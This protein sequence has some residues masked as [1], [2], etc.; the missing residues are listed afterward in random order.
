MSFVASCT[1]ISTYF[2][3][4]PWQGSYP[5]V[6]N[7]QTIILICSGV[8]VQIIHD[9]IKSTRWWYNHWVP[10][11]GIGTHTPCCKR[12]GQE[13]AKHWLGCGPEQLAQVGSQGWHFKAVVSKNCVGLPHVGRH[14]PLLGTGSVGG[15]DVHWSKEGPWQLSQSGWQGTQVL[16]EA[17]LLEAKVPDG[18]VGT[19]LPDEAN[20]SL[21]VRQRPEE[22]EQVSQDDGHAMRTLVENNKKI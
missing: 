1:E 18:Q 13:H 6:A 4:Y 12:N 10:R 19:H 5:Y 2:Y 9:M 7:F 16:L 14:R 15:H 11:M 22:P 21:Q 17:V 3:L 20:P 8:W